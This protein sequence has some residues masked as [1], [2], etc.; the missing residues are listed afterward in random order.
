MNLNKKKI[1]AEATYYTLSHQ[2]LNKSEVNI[3]LAPVMIVGAP[4]SGTT[5]LQKLLLENV[6]I[7]GGQESQFCN[8]FNNAFLSAMNEKDSRKVGL[9]AYWEVEDFKW[10]M[11]ELWA[12]TFLPML[13]N[14]PEATV[15][16]E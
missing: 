4:R 13:N 5:W 15:L 7:C 8:V 1:E 6:A 12:R 10:Q 3:L 16:L 11:R 2:P 9:S 14:K